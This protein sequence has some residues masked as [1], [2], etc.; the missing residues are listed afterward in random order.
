[1]DE[2]SGLDDYIFWVPILLVVGV[3]GAIWAFDWFSPSNKYTVYPV[4]CDG[5][6]SDKKCIGKLIPS[7]VIN[8][9]INSSDKTVIF[10]ANGTLTTQKDCEIFD[11]KNWNC[12]Y[13]ENF[14]SLGLK[15]GNVY[16]YSIEFGTYDLS[17]IDLKQVSKPNYFLLKWFKSDEGI[18]NYFPNS[19]N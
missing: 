3:V 11:K 12:P 18:S 9:K 16:I 13:G 7:D 8:F 19:L 1:M 6:I 10:N 15:N 2:Y 17:S 5:K 14:S 4:K